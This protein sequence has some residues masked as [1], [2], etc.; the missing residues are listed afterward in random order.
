[1]G[2]NR[3]LSHTSACASG[4]H[5]SQVVSV[6]VALSMLI[7]GRKKNQDLLLKLGNLIESLFHR[8]R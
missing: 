6:D 1:M 3:E 4:S 5:D 2:V 7:E 8:L